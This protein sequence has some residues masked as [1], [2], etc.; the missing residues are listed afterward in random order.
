MLKI[1][2]N[3]NYIFLVLITLVLPFLCVKTTYPSRICGYAFASANSVATDT[4]LLVRG[5]VFILI[6]AAMLALTFIENKLSCV[7]YDSKYTSGLK[8]FGKNRSVISLLIKAAP[9][10]YLTFSILSTIFSVDPVVSIAGC[11]EQLEGIFI[12]AAYVILYYLAG[13][14]MK[15]EEDY[16]LL[17]VLLSIESIVFLLIA[18]LQ[19]LAGIG[20]VYLTLYNSNYAG[21]YMTMLFLYLLYCCIENRGNRGSIRAGRFRMLYICGAA[22]AFLTVILTGAKS[23]IVIAIAVALA[24]LCDAFI[25]R[26]EIYKVL[27]VGGILIFILINALS[28]GIASGEPENITDNADRIDDIRITSEGVYFVRGD[29]TLRFTFDMPDAEHFVFGVYDEAGNEV[30]YQENAEGTMY[31]V[32]SAR[33][34]DYHFT[35]ADYGGFTGFLVH[36]GNRDWYFYH[37]EDG[38]YYYLNGYS[39]GEKFILAEHVLFEG[40]E[41]FATNRGYIW[42]R[43]FPLLLGRASG[44]EAV[45]DDIMRSIKDI[46]EGK[47]KMR[48]ADATNSIMRSVKNTLIGRGLDT[49]AIAFPQNDLGMYLNTDFQYKTIITKPHSIYLQLLVQQGICGLLL[50]FTII[51]SAVYSDRKRSATN[52]AASYALFAFLLCGFFYDSSLCIMPLV[53]LLAGS[54]VQAAD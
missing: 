10:L 11:D 35:L 36:A 45:P 22:G 29:N 51:G 40:N 34:L 14:I 9:L 23:A 16:R 33:F 53:W 52:G 24:I 54:S 38:D 7:V 46:Q 6:C 49:F 12:I 39:R 27:L 48:Y 42:S 18:L 44:Y 32:S 13:Y 30:P 8:S 43:T 3:K 50:F 15:S 26:S 1:L 28:I 47:E 2:K 25:K 37:A 31:E 4:Y 17:G 5:I 21:Q 41:A 19:K 20:E